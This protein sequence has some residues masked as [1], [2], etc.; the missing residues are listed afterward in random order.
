MFSPA[1]AQEG[2]GSCS[3]VNYEDKTPLKAALVGSEVVVSSINSQHHAAQ[4]VIAR[5]AKAASI[6]LFVPTEFGFRDE[7]G[8]NN[9][10]QKVRDLLTQLELPF[11]L[12]HSGLWTEN[13]P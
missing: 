3:S 5:A 9:T 12:F 7:D 1:G 8:A 4:F 6:Q 2:V 11:A 10:K 13:L